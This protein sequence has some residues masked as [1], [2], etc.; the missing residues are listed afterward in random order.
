MNVT[1]LVT[2][3]TTNFYQHASQSEQ[4][5]WLRAALLASLA[6]GMPLARGLCITHVLARKKGH[7]HSL[8]A[9]R[10]FWLAFENLSLARARNTWGI[11]HEALCAFS[12]GKASQQRSQSYLYRPAGLRARVLSYRTESYDCEECRSQPLDI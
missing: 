10:D 8:V 9:R 7:T 3:T 2:P 11:T 12:Q 4:N 1:G 6:R 5:L